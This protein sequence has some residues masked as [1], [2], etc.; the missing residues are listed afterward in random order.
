MTQPDLMLPMKMSLKTNRK[1]IK[2][3][4]SPRELASS[5][6]ATRSPAQILA[7]LK[8]GADDERRI[9]A[10]FASDSGKTKGKIMQD[11]MQ[12]AS[13]LIAEWKRPRQ[14]FET[15]AWHVSNGTKK[16]K[17]DGFER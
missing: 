4:P 1:E 12:R 2:M 9:K 15:D 8:S 17:E 14:T 3:Q 6:S 16:S 7:D 13:E 11:L 10:D 5:E